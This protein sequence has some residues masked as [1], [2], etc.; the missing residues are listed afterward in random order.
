M[1]CDCAQGTIA[2]HSRNICTKST[3][4][5]MPRCTRGKSLEPIDPYIE[6]T[7]RHLRKASKVKRRIQMGEEKPIN[8]EI[9]PPPTTP[10]RAP[11]RSFANLNMA[12]INRGIQAPVVGANNFEIKTYEEAV[13]LIENLAE[14]NYATPRS[15]TKRVAN[16]QESEELK[17]IKAQLAAII[18]QLKGA[19]IQ[20]ALNYDG[21]IPNLFLASHEPEQMA[22][23]KTLFGLYDS[24]IKITE[25]KDSN[26][27]RLVVSIKRKFLWTN[28]VGML[29]HCVSQQLVLPPT[30][31]TILSN[32]TLT[33]VFSFYQEHLCAVSEPVIVSNG[34]LEVY[35]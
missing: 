5:F 18:N 4:W 1:T 30:L 32:S 31:R 11:M 7:A 19:S 12:A 22:N 2:W 9:P 28:A 26:G 6:R 3:N 16:V 24:L 27:V 17:A 13:E 8:D 23:L 35:G 21:E 20:P 34:A 29:Q 14:H 15:T 33:L 10:G 25:N